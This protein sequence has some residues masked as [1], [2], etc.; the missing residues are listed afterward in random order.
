MIKE[1]LS[2]KQKAAILFLLLGEDI[3]AEIFKR[4]NDDEV[5]EISR[6]ISLIKAVP[7]SVSDAVAEE[8]Y[9]MTLARQYMT[10]GGIDYAKKV[11]IKSMGSE[12]ARK[13]IDPLAKIVEK[14]TGFSALEKINPQQLS[15]FI[16]HEHP[17]TIALI[18]AHLS[19]HQ[20]AQLIAALPEDIRT[21]VVIRMANLEEISPEIV[22]KIAGVLD[23]KLEALGSYSLEE[24]GGVKAVSELF[25]RMDRRSSRNILEQ[26]ESR[27]P[28]LAASIKD[29]MFV[30]DDILL[31][32]D[33]GIMEILKRIDKKSLASALKGSKEELR[34]K[35]FKNMSQRAGEMLKEEMEYLGPIRVKDVEKAQHEIVEVIRGLEEEGIIVVG[36]SGGEEYVI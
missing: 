28:G 32:D 16:Q 14:T 21:E 35:F 27:D 17:Q 26:I 33:Q 4:L 12:N 7:P 5:Q 3:T 15:K 23:Q 36:D 22:K 6:E 8:F 11:L 31:I 10:V 19:N 29:L 24:Y 20:A 30:F 9:H 25:N 1:R 34:D 2:G 13:I 18:L